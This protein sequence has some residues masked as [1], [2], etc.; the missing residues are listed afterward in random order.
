MIALSRNGDRVVLVVDDG[1]EECVVRMTPEAASKIASDLIRLAHSAKAHRDEVTG[2][3]E[4][5]ATVRG[6]GFAT[7]QYKNHVTIFSEHTKAER[8][9]SRSCYLCRE[10]IE[11]GA[12]YWQEA[13]TV[14]DKTWSGAMFCAP[15]VQPE[16]RA[17]ALM[18]DVA[19]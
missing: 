16:L 13:Q 15:C 9:R 4:L 1:E 7:V 8:G 3:N 11:P 12:R 14:K 6:N 5:R 2:A 17:A 19:R 10:P 18:K